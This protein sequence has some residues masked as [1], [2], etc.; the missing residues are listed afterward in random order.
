MGAS[1]CSTSASS[2]N[3]V[4]R[5]RPLPATCPSSV[6][7]LHVAPSRREARLSDATDWYSV[8]VMLYQALTGRPPFKGS[9][10]E[11]QEHKQREELRYPREIVAIF[12]TTWPCCARACPARS[13]A[14]PHGR[15]IL[16]RLG[17]EVDH[18]GGATRR[19]QRR[20]DAAAAGRAEESP[21][22]DAG[23]VRRNAGRASDHGLRSR[24]RAWASR[25]SSGTSW[26]RCSASTPKRSAGGRCYEQES[27]PYKALD[28]LI[29]GLSQYLPPPAGSAAELL[30][31]EILA[32]SRLFPVLGRVEAIASAR[33]DVLEIPDPQEQ[34]RRGFVAL[35]ELLVRLAREHPLVLFV[36]DL[37]WGDVDSAALF[38]A[39]AAT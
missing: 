10:V 13:E 11:M 39:R 32:L 37:Q 34:R 22:C 1:C 30:P 24:R 9:F 4:R 20:F 12:P 3:W 7:E 27:V 15:E 38:A 17:H 5:R 18:A 25:S 29:D 2:P 28:Q 35:R 8:G 6:A 23:G 26:T 21:G 31:V 16:R 14:A 36:D 33:R 19:S